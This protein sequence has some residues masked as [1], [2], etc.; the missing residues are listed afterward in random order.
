MSLETTLC[1]SVYALVTIGNLSQ[2]QHKSMGTRREPLGAIGG[3]RGPL[4]AIGICKK[5]H[6]SG[7]SPLVANNIL[8][9][10]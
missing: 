4:G 10:S 7:R 8:K 6:V 5:K 2:F 9:I 3:H 1:G